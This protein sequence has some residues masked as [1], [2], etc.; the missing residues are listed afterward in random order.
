MEDLLKVTEARSSLQKRN[1]QEL[2]DTPGNKTKKPI[3]YSLSARGDL[4]GPSASRERNWV[5]SLRK[6]M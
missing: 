4:E 1:E 6:V 3:C 5:V 2:V